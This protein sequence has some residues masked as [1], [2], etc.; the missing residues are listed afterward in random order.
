MLPPVSAVS[1]S[2]AAVTPRE[3]IAAAETLAGQPS[4]PDGTVALSLAINSGVEGK[5][6]MLLINARE[7]MINSLFAV[8]DAVSQ[9]LALPR[10]AGESN[11]A[12]ALRLADAMSAQAPKEMAALQQRLSAQ[13]QNAPLLLVAAALHDPTGPEAAQLVAY[14]EVVRYKEKDLATRTVVASYGQ[15]DGNAET[16]AKSPAGPVRS[17][18][19]QAAMLPTPAVALPAQPTSRM[20]PAG[21]VQPIVPLQRGFDTPSPAVTA[22]Q[23]PADAQ[24]RAD[25][26]PQPAALRSQT[27]TSADSAPAPLVNQQIQADI[28]EGLK[29]VF[30]R[31]VQATGTQLLQTLAEAEPLAD[32]VIAQALVAD[33]ID[34]TVLN[35]LPAPDLTRSAPQAL[36]ALPAA[37]PVSSPAATPAS[38]AAVSQMAEDRPEPTA[39]PLAQQ[40]SALPAGLAVGFVTTPYAPAGGVAEKKD[41]S[42]IDRV[43]AVDDDEHDGPDHQAQ[44]DAEPEDE[45]ETPAEEALDMLEAHPDEPQTAAGAK[46]FQ[47]ASLAALPRPAPAEPLPSRGYDLYQRMGA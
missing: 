13:G 47:R 27:Q 38:L 44:Q 15:N 39:A 7:R 32:K 31:L 12:Y 26:A 1:A 9:S 2:S 25:A 42:R 23:H 45:P 8:I 28:K 24:A 5:L 34:E 17:A 40:A 22:P 21:P 37:V 29:V 20:Q 19:A 35:S 36:T 18:P 41:P 46:G 6:N 10:D 14:L 16:G 11:A 30:D 4:S 33:M 3:V 43:D